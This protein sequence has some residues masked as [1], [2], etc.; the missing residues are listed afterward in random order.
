MKKAVL[1]P[2]SAD[3]T[4]LLKYWDR[5]VSDYEIFKV[6]SPLGS[7]LCGQDAGMADNRENMGI[8]VSGSLKEV[9]Q[10]IETLIVPYV[11]REIGERLYLAD[12][13][14][15][16][17]HMGKEI[18]CCFSLTKRERKE[19]KAICSKKGTLFLYGLDNHSDVWKQILFKMNE[20]SIPVIFVGGIFAEANNFEVVLSLA[21]KLKKDGYKVSAVGVRPEYNL[22]GFHY[23][24]PLAELVNGHVYGKKMSTLIT[25]LN[26]CLY[27]LSIQEHLDVLIVDVPGGLIDTPKYPN[28]SGVY[29]YILSQV[30]KPDYTIL[31]SLYS[32]AGETDFKV[33]LEEIEK[34]FGFEAGCVHMSNKYLAVQES[35]Q[36]RSMEFGHMPIDQVFKETLEFDADVPK[37]CFFDESQ[38]E[39]AYQD[40]LLMLSGERV[41]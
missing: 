23:L 34:R 31:T 7:G 20:I 24:W 8:Q 36:I 12:Q 35:E 29:A 13:M 15:K 3:H 26:G 28:E 11:T 21:T 19:I 4:A 37:Y 25:L 6:V 30:I 16:I 41:R 14:R 27:G 39:K 9:L 40:I 17:A 38:L 1:Y 10:D 5:Y 2:F 32:K 18:I 22:L 33:L